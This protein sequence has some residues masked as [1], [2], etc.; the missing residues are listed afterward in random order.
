MLNEVQL[1]IPSH[2]PP[3]VAHGPKDRFETLCHVA[4]DISAAPCTRKPGRDGRICCSREFDVVLLVGLTE[5]KAQI[6]WL[7]SKTVRVYEWFL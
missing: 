3:C 4:A 7:D 2:V 6:R 1:S 5:L